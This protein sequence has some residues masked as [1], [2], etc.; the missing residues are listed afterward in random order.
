M[1]LGEKIM[2]AYEEMSLQQEAI[3]RK[4]HEIIPS[5]MAHF[6]E[7]VEKV[8]NLSLPEG[9]SLMR[10]SMVTYHYGKFIIHTGLY[11]TPNGATRGPLPSGRKVMELLEAYKK[12]NPWVELIQPK[13][14]TK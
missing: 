10:S 13:F 2:S 7:Y 3:K 5:V 9:I 6:N 8:I 11:H 14:Y 12:E 4:G 1:D